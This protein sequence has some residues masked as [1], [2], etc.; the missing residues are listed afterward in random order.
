MEISFD[1]GSVIS[2]LKGSV[3]KYRENKTYD[4][5]A[6]DELLEKYAKSVEIIEQL[7]AKL[8]EKNNEITP[9]DAIGMI[10]QVGGI[11]GLKALADFAKEYGDKK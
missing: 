3:S 10:S 11:E 1:L 6:Y 2:E 7:K 4:K 8:D 9:K 5:K